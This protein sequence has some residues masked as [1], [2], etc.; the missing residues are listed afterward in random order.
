MLIFMA[1]PL[2]KPIKYFYKTTVEVHTPLN[3][4]QNIRQLA[5]DIIIPL[6]Q[7]LTM[8]RYI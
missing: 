2:M 7:P 6:T 5:D 3:R 1:L 8:T 4:F